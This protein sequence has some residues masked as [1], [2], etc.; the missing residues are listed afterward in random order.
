ME[1]HFINSARIVTH[2]FRKAYRQDRYMYIES[3]IHNWE[4][5]W[6]MKG[7]Q[8]MEKKMEGNKYGFD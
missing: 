5:E 2:N 3:A 6:E 7:G 1:F 4:R 8:N